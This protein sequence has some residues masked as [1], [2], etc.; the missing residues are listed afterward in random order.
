GGDTGSGDFQVVLTGPDCGFENELRRRIAGY[1]LAGKILFTGA[2]PPEE[3]PALMRAA[4]VFCLPSWREG[5][6]NTVVEALACGLPVVATGVGGIP[7]MI[8]EGENGLLVPLRDAWKLTDGL[9]KAITKDWIPERIPV[10][11]EP[12]YYDK[13]AMQIS[14]IYRSI[15]REK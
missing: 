10:T 3:I 1:G 15:I 9:R 12:F 11:A 14:G 6:P 4:D 7:E 2:L 13:L 8:R 5:W